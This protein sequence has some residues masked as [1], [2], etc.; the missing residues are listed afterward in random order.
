MRNVTR[1]GIAALLICSACLAGEEHKVV[2]RVK[3][4]PFESATKITVHMDMAPTLKVVIENNSK[5]PF[6]YRV[7]PSGRIQG[8]RFTLLWHGRTITRTDLFR[9]PQDLRVLKPKE[10]IEQI[11]PFKML[12]I[13]PGPWKGPKWL[14]SG[15][16][17]GIIEFEQA[18]PIVHDTPPCLRATLKIAIE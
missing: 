12:K 10:K 17:A 5:R 1:Y 9:A 13:M 6:N 7:F 16:Y 3:K 2:L 14:H 4:G 11:I 15:D 18:R 8:L